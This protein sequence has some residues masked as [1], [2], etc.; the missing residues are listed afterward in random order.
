MVQWKKMFLLWSLNIFTVPSSSYFPE[1]TYLLIF[2]VFSAPRGSS[3]ENHRQRN[4]FSLKMVRNDDFYEGPDQVRNKMAENDD[5]AVQNQRCMVAESSGAGGY[6]EM[7]PI[8]A[9]Q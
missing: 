9:D 8:L 5:A 2:P 4:E 6:K 1:F 7:S 3:L